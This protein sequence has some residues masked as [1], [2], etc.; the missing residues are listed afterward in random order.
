ML[1]TTQKAIIDAAKRHGLS[2]AQTESILQVDAAHEIKILLNSGKKYRGF[3]MQHNNARGPYK[4]GIR[5]HSEVDFEEVQALATL[6]SLKTALVRVPLGGGKGGIEVNPRD[7]SVEELE[8]LSRK[9]VRAL[10]D[11][12]GPHV[13]IP[14]PDVN[15][16]AQIM[17][18]MTDEFAQMTGDETNASFTGKS[19]ENGGSEGRSAATGRGGLYVLERYLELIEDD[20][21]K[22]FAIQGFGNVGAHFAELV[23]ERFPTWKLVAA[24]DSS[25][26]L[27]AQGGLDPE[28]LSEYK[29]DR[30]RFVDYRDLHV[31][32]VDAEQFLEL[33]VDIIVF[34]ALGGVVNEHNQNGIQAEL[35]VELA[36]GPLDDSAQEELQKRSIAVLPDIL[37]NAGG[38]VVSYFEWQQNL[39]SERWSEQKVNTK[40]REIMRTATDTVF[41]RLQ[42]KNGSLKDAAFDVAV[43]RLLTAIEKKK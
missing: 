3:R 30:G 6:M 40:L 2:A 12:L 25:G 29:K 28:Q 8:E 32:H 18:W 27:Y 39:L 31:K 1:K 15:T 36:N 4:G 16:N 22:T 5:F 10:G 19:L 38:V 24:S 11:K 23:A 14:A 7:L 34:A 35:L 20:K 42:K 37:A 33:P 26:G 43:Q 41:E 9:Y 21:P 13:D 17:D